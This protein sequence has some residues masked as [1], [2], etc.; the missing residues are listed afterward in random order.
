MPSQMTSL[1]QDFPRTS[2]THGHELFSILL[3]L[4]LC[5]LRAQIYSIKCEWILIIRAA[6]LPAGLERWQCS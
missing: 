2:S 1:I 4:P 3:C 6:E 5:A